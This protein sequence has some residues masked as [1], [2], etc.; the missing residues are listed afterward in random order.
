MSKKSSKPLNQVKSGVRAF[1]NDT[2]MMTIDGQ[3]FHLGYSRISKYMDCPRQYKYSY[4]DKIPYK[5]GVAMAR[6]T[7]YH[8]TLE[9]LLKFKIKNERLAPHPAALKAA[10][11]YAAEERLSASETERVQFAV[12]FYW[13]HLYEKHQ[14]MV[15]EYPFEIVRGGVKLT[16]RIDLVE[17]DGMITDHKFSADTWAE[18][19]AKY[20]VQPIIYQWAGIDVLEKEFEGW[21]Y[22]GFSYNIIRTFPT[23]VVQTIKIPRLTTDES[24]WYEE[25]VYEI[26]QGIRN[27]VFLPRPGD[28]AC[29]WCSYKDICQPGIYSLKT[30]LI[31]QKKYDEEDI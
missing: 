30:G 23:P 5:A 1:S 3:E 31:G 2:V 12:D 17:T 10:A 9:A 27:G 11:H 14:P 28:Q 26:A 15:V 8:N 24:D 22:T 25:Q 4:V 7:A 19:R 21:E 18:G 6:G 16:G 13:H 29:K 20:G